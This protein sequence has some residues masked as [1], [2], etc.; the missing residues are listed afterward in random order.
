[1]KKTEVE[2]LDELTARAEKQFG[3]ARTEELRVDIEQTSADLFKIAGF[4]VEIT[5]A[6]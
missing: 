6:P 2:I 3:T 4:P 1:M 5:D